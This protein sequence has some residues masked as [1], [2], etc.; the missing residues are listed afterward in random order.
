MLNVSFVRLEVLMHGNPLLAM[1]AG[2]GGV[3][4]TT[5]FASLFKRFKTLSNHFAS[6]SD[7][8]GSVFGLLFV[9]SL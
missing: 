5:V 1:A 7:H 3:R 4:K 8:F 6:V 2:D 9:F